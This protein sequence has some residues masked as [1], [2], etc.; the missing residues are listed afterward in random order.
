MA[1]GKELVAV[2]ATGWRLGLSNL[3]Q[4]ENG[5]WWKTRLWRTQS[6]LW[7]LVINGILAATLF[8]ESNPAFPISLAEKITT[9][10]TLFTILAGIMPAIAV[11]I[12]GQDA[13]IGEKHSGTAAWILS[14]P[15][16]REAYILSKFVANTLGILVTMV[17]IP[18]IGAY[19]L[20]WVAGGQTLPLLPFLGALGLL[21]INLVFYLA[22]T[23]MLGT[24]FSQ[25]GPVI[26][27]GLVIALGYQLFLAVAPWL[28]TVMPWGLVYPQSDQ[29]PS[30]AQAVI[31]SLQIQTFLPLLAT[32]VWIVGMLA[33]AILKFKQEE[34]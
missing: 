30:L 24:L 16:S 14:K 9:A 11:I 18:G 26:G 20:L 28:S 5:E 7:L 25:R 29:T 33:V 6:I 1:S 2:S 3:L 27:L 17:L 34:F 12:R 8:S 32:L 15:A 21:L 23:L 31:Q 19:L 22:L 4:K 13:I 10:L